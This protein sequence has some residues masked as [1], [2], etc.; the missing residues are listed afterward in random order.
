MKNESKLNK[1]RRQM[2]RLES[3]L[4]CLRELD[5]QEILVDDKELKKTK[6]YSKEISPEAAR[7]M[8]ENRKRK[9][10]RKLI[11]KLTQK[12]TKLSAEEALESRLVILESKLDQLLA[13]DGRTGKGA[14]KPKKEKA[15]TQASERFSIQIDTS[16]DLERSMGC[17][18]RRN[19]ERHSCSSNRLGV[20]CWTITSARRS[21]YEIE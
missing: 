11:K 16:Q 1:L 6:L 3:R 21:R 18:K 2:S 5:N 4:K 17:E 9:Q 7:W 8:E 10:R 19:S 14:A 13:V 20:A 12:L 15:P